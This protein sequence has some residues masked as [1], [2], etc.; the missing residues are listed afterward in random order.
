MN[1]RKRPKLT[2]V[3]AAGLLAGASLVAGCDDN[4]PVDVDRARYATQADC[5]KDWSR[6]DDCVFIE[7]GPQPA[8]AASST[9]GGSGSSGGG[10]HGGGHW[11]GPYYTRS[12][13]VYHHD[14]DETTERIS[15]SNAASVDESRVPAHS[16]TEAGRSGEIARGGFGESAH[17]G[18]EAGGHGGGGHGGGG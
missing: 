11:Y 5:E 15:T 9:S 18:G 7:D 10:A 14:G 16:L 8:S 3:G 17:G 13:T 4:T 1:A 2:L 12:G 6:A